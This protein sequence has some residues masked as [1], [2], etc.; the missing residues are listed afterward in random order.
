MTSL[1]SQGGPTTYEWLEVA[2]RNLSD[3]VDDDPALYWF[4]DGEIDRILDLAGVA[5]HEGGHK[6]NAPL[7][8]YLIGLAHG[9][10][11]DLELAEVIARA[12]G[13]RV[14]S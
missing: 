8:S 3:G 6:S 13:D 5:A 11:P 12:I 4:E 2:A 1:S 9:R 14:P 7:L 10:H